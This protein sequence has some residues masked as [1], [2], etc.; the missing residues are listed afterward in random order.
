MG[1]VRQDREALFPD[2]IFA[3]RQGGTP[4][5]N[6]VA[7]DGTL[8]PVGLGHTYRESSSEIVFA[9]SADRH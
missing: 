8:S 9:R 6:G 2:L 5:S 1:R 3:D 4:L 7:L